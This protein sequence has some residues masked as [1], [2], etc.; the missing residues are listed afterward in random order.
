MGRQGMPRITLPTPIRCGSAYCQHGAEPAVER[1]RQGPWRLGRP[2][3]RSLTVR[4][5]G[6]CGERASVRAP[7]PS[8]GPVAGARWYGS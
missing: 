8:S 3:S 6:G 4:T 1:G 7:G 5:G 2:L